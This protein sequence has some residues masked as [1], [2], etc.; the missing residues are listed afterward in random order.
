M[1]HRLLQAVGQSAGSGVPGAAFATLRRHVHSLQL[2]RLAREIAGGTFDTTA[3]GHPD[4]PVPATDRPTV[5]D[6]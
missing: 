5:T 1:D 3:I 4:H 2:A 6:L